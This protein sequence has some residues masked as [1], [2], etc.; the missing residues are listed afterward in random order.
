[1]TI[2][3][4]LGIL[5]QSESISFPKISGRYLGS[6]WDVFLD[7]LLDQNLYVSLVELLKKYNIRPSTNYL[8]QPTLF[9]SLLNN[10]NHLQS[11]YLSPPCLDFIAC[12]E[13]PYLI[14]IRDSGTTLLKD[15]FI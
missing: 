8:N 1:M 4:W 14:K 2:K 5:S 7:W 12:D 3:D 15:I 11:G 13:W 6:D 9:L 10:R